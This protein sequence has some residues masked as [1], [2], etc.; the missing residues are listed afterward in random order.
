VET[1]PKG[2]DETLLGEVGYL[3][4]A[5]R[6]SKSENQRFENQIETFTFFLRDLSL[7]S[8]VELLNVPNLG[9]FTFC[10]REEHLK[11]QPF[12]A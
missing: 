3:L 1:T 5:L 11:N 10:T 4:S 12:S 7:A 9:S 2:R 8:Y 6:F